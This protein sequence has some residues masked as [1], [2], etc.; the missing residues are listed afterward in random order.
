MF[1]WGVGEQ[2]KSV[3]PSLFEHGGESE[4]GEPLPTATSTRAIG[5]R[6][7]HFR[8]SFARAACG[9]GA[10]CPTRSLLC[11]LRLAVLNVSRGATRKREREPRQKGRGR[12]QRTC[13]LSISS[14]FSMCRLVALRATSHRAS[15]N[16]ALW[17]VGPVS[18]N[19]RA[20]RN[21]PMVPCRWVLVS[22]F[23][24]FRFSFPRC[25]RTRA[26]FPHHAIWGG[27]GSGG[28]RKGV[29]VCCVVLAACSSKQGAFG[30]RQTGAAVQQKNERRRRRRWARARQETR[31]PSLW[32]HLPDT[33]DPQQL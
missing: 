6:R 2:S 5:G 32:P 17:N 33:F 16:A 1:F 9:T 15:P 23:R 19:A 3:S 21:S 12:K 8:L 7:C 11:A 29:R 28:G 18:L 30:R 14:G 13:W 10:A 25:T 24:W 22:S 20:R 27:G 31:A 26:A 4:G